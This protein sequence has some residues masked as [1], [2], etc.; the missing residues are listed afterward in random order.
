MAASGDPVGSGIVA[1]LNRPG[2]NVTGLSSSLTEAY[3]KRIELL[4]E[5]L[6]GLARV[7]VIF[8]MSNPSV[9]PQWKEV[10][11]A[12]R[13]LGMQAQLLDVRSPEDL[14]KAF[15]AAKKQRAQA[16][17]VG[18]DGVTQ[19]NLRPIAELAA[20]Q[21]LASI[22]GEKEYAVA[23]GLIAYGATD[24]SMYYRA[25]NFVDKIFKGA[26]PAE[27]PIEQPTRFDLTIN[28]KTAK[29]LG[30]SIPHGVLI[31][32]DSVLE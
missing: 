14:G 22:Y 3:A 12:A 20:K 28:L 2:G 21:H 11:I 5:M 8:N 18:L 30:L 15:D 19:A 17:L 6:P 25:A 23:G 29:A 31:R 16:L 10:E 1:S 24:F 4:S 13:K 7:A 32:A 26:K 27:L 9:P